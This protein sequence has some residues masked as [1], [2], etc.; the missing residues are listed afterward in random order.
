MTTWPEAVAR[1]GGD[2]GTAG[3]AQA[4]LEARYGEPH[5][6]YHDLGH[7]AAVARDSAALAAHLPAGERAA[8]ALAAWA[9]D[10]VYDAVPGE[11]ERRSAEWLR[12]WLTRAGVA[13]PHVA[14]AEALV[15][16]T[17]AHEAPDG[18]DAA[19]A[20]LDADLA[21]L[22]ADPSSYAGYVAAVRREYA[23]YAD[24]TWAAGRAA[25]LANLLARPVLYR[26]GIARARWET[27]ARANL[28]AELTR[29][30]ANAGDRR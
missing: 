10:V 7:A 28:A 21:I 19:A 13:E 12:R 2:A 27:A 9:H 20:L 6:H 25:V 30:R 24:E 29:W 4:D 17:A 26:S 1:V 16:A 8:I 5:R 3:E 18:D 15:L 14:R 11:D 23:K 22:G